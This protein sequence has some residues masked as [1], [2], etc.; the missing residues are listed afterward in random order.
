MRRNDGGAQEE[1][2]CA[3]E[4]V[5]SVQHRSEVTRTRREAGSSQAPEKRTPPPFF[6]EPDYL[7]YGLCWPG[8]GGKTSNQSPIEPNKPGLEMT[9]LPNR[10]LTSSTTALPN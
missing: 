10:P 9:S 1:R 7:V 6:W 8:L 3:S 2:Q 5:R 4:E